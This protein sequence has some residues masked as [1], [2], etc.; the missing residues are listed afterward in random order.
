MDSAVDAHLGAAD[1]GY[2]N[3]RGDAGDNVGETPTLV[4][5]AT[6][7]WTSVHMVPPTGADPHAT[8]VLEG[9]M[10]SIGAD[11]VNF[12]S[13]Q[14]RALITL[15]DEA[16]LRVK[17]KEVNVQTEESARHEKPLERAC[18]S[19]SKGRKGQ[20]PY[21]Y[22]GRDSKAPCPRGGTVAGRHLRGH[23]RQQR[24]GVH[25]Q[26]AWGLPRVAV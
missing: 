5:T 14:E 12:R 16:T 23:A 26:R 2:L 1:R 8:L 22:L 18:R 20:G 15:K 13:D 19:W 24:R 10:A 7:G 3:N 17:Q 4:T 6:D 9:E 11:A 25:P 21:A